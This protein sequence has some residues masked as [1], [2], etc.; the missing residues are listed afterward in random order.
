MEVYRDFARSFFGV[1]G[2]AVPGTATL[3]GQAL[4]SWMQYSMSP[5]N[6]AWLA[7]MFT[8]HYR[9]T[10]DRKFLEQKAMPFVSGVGRFLLNM[11]RTD[12]GGKYYLPLSTSP[13]IHD[14][15]LEAYLTP[16]S[17]YDLAL[18]RRLFMDL[19]YL[20]RELHDEEQAGYWE[21]RLGK[22]PDLA[23]DSETGLML[24]PDEILQ[25]SHR[26][27]AHL[28]AIYPLRLL[29][30]AGDG[31][32]IRKSLLHLDKRGTGMWVGFSVVWISAMA[33]FCGN[34]GRALRMLK[35]FL[36]GFVSRNG[37]NLNGDYKDYGYC[38]W[39]YRPFTI[40]TN[41]LAMQTVH[42]MLLQSYEGEY[43]IFPAVPPEW[44][45]IEFRDLRG[46]GGVMVSAKRSAGKLEYA[47][48][49]ATRAC[50]IR[51]HNPAANGEK[52]ICSHPDVWRQ[53]EEMELALKAGEEFSLVRA[54]LG[55]DVTSPER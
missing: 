28:M 53:G 20:C 27:H 50:R 36:D 30:M 37:F 9:Y 43:R 49:R 25:E 35:I 2:I 10:M 15:R 31:E 16:T 46:E 8:D 54:G 7:T 12:S 24:S 32:L 33:A 29:N 51:L 44:P 38:W 17:N 48:L 22:L 47:K 13:E 14:D 34:A 5:T 42:E 1:D 52:L 18:I 26:H 23:V 6:S 21:S 55:D 3:G 39:K 19:R 4:G 45:E 41:F 40:E 11:L